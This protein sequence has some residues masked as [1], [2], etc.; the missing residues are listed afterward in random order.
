MMVDQESPCVGRPA[1]VGAPLLTLADRPSIAIC[2]PAR[3]E[4]ATIN[5]VVGAAM[6]ALQAWKGR[7]DE[8]VVVDDGSTDETGTLASAAGARVIRT[9]ASGKGDA[10]RQAVWATSA[11]LLVFLDADLT[12]ANPSQVHDLVQPLLDDHHTMLVKPRYRRDLFGRPGEGGR[13]T[14]LVARPLLQLYWPELSQVAQPLAGE[15]AV[16][17]AALDRVTL[18]DGYAVDLA[19]LIDIYLTFGL[20]AIAQVD[21]GT[22]VHRNRPLREL[23]PQAAAILAM[24]LDRALQ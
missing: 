9:R 11:E 4:A 8:V 16:R 18:A 10:L 3:D 22:R 2:I 14:E 17:R 24:A 5:H 23:T 15:F 1:D 20:D 6:E 12:S 13:V 7:A 19:L 21:L